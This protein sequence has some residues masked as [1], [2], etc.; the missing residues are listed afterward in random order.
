VPAELVF[1]QGFGDLFV[2]RVAGNIIDDAIL[3]SVEYAAEH[4]G[5]RLILVLGHERC[6]AVDAALGGGHVPGHVSSLVKAIKPA[7][8][9]AKGQP[10][11]PLDN[12]VRANVRRVAGQVRAS[13][14]I[15]AKMVAAGKLQVVGARYDLD[16]GAVE[17]V[18]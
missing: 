9:T 7:V 18:R 14:P 12:A 15:L 10:G 4:L 2:I 13:Q 5:P 11:D 3:G 17:M 6:G 1:D 16:T 8:D